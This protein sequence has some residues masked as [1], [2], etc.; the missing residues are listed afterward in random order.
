[1]AVG[2]GV[3]LAIAAGF[4]PTAVAAQAAAAVTATARVLPAVG[5][6]PR[7]F[8]ASPGTGPAGSDSWHWVFD[9]EPGPGLPSLPA[10]TVTRQ[11][12]GDR[13]VI[14]LAVTGA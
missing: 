11:V 3:G 9:G 10:M 4:C 8:E 12:V 6:L 7:Q 14:E 2:L 13:R 5:V 1:M